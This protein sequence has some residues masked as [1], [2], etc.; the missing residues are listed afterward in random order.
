MKTLL[1]KLAEARKALA[2]VAGIVAQVV[3]LGVLSGT[4]L[5]D[6]QAV[7]AVLT[8]VGVYA[9]PNKPPTVSAAPVKKTA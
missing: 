4:A 7:L 2:V 6:V 3:A 5:H 8:A 1:A 9:V